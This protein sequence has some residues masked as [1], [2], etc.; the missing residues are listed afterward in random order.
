[1]DNLTIQDAFTPYYSGRKRFAEGREISVD[2]KDKEARKPLPHDAA[3]EAW[4]ETESTT[5]H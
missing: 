1:M 3:A 4:T 5:E 2:S